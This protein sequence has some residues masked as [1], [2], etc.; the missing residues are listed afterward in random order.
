MLSLSQD[1]VSTSLAKQTGLSESE[2]K[3]Y[4]WN[5][6]RDEVNRRKVVKFGEAMWRSMFYCSFCVLGFITLCRPTYVPWLLDT[7]E[8]F[9]NWPHHPISTLMNFYY[10]IEL[11]CYIHQLHWTEVNRS[12]ALEMILHHVIT[13]ALILGSYL[14]NFTRVGT[15]ILLCHDFA[16]I[17]LEIGKCFNYTSKTPEFKS[18]ASPV[19][20]FLFVCFSLSFLI[21]RL[22]IYP[23][24]LLYSVVIESPHILGMWSGYWYFAILLCSLQVL[25]VFWFYLILKMAYRIMI[26]GEVE[27]DV[28]SED[29]ELPEEEKETSSVDKK[30]DKKE[31][32]KKW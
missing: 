16:D 28:R 14:I 10:Q 5:R 23:R 7:S 15:S 19:T 3:R 1:E 13:I 4:I 11:G 26:V 25:H 29:D 12:D 27:K 20:D 18:I 17:F 31:N 6:N 21:T 22:V 24:F 30:S 9:N 8:N 32:K 2:V